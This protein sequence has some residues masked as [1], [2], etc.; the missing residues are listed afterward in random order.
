MKVN[1][2]SRSYIVGALIKCEKWEVNE[3][4]HDFAI[5]YQDSSAELT[6]VNGLMYIEG[7]DIAVPR[8]A[9]Y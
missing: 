2:R 4:L 9:Y 6:R 5:K 1:F 7:C 3:S 8:G